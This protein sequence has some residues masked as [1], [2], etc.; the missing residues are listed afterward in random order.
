[1]T[2]KNRIYVLLSLPFF[3]FLHLGNYLNIIFMKKMKHLLI[4]L[5]TLIA[6]S[7]TA[8]MSYPVPMDEAV[9]TGK[10]DNGL[11]YYVRHNGY[12]EHRVNFYIAQRVGSIQENDDQRGLAHFLEHMAFNGSDHFRGNEL[13]EYCRSLG[14]EFGGDLNAYT[15]IDQTVYRICN[16]PSA[17]QTALDSCLLILRDWS[18]GL[19]LEADEIQ[20]ERGVIHEEWRLRTSPI[21]R[22]LE[23]NLEALYPGSKYGKRM[24][25]GLMEIID[26][27]EP[28]VLRDYYHKWYR[29]DNQAII[30]VGDVDVDHTVAK[31]RELFAPIPLAA[32]AAPVVKEPVPDTPQPIVVIDKD[33]EQRTNIVEVMFKHEAEPDSVKSDMMYLM[34]CYVKDMVTNMLNTRLQEVALE[35]DCPFVNASC[36]DGSY[37]LAHTV[38]CFSLSIMPKEGKTTEAV[39]AAYTEVERALQHGFTASEYSRA[40]AEYLS[41]LD[42]AYTNRNKTENSRFGDACRDH[43]LSN[44]PLTSIE[45]DKQV[46]D[47]M[48]PQ[49]PV[50]AA[51]EM[52]RDLVS[53]TD[54]NVVI[55]SFNNDKE[56]AT[57]PTA[58]VLYGAIK[59]VR[60]Q[61]L[62]AWVDNV[63]DEPLIANM[64]E[65]GRIVSEE[66][67]TT[68]GYKKWQLSNGAKVV[69]KKT[70]FKDDEIMM[71][72]YSK[73]GSSILGVED[74]VNASLMGA[75]VSSSKL[76]GFTSTELEKALAGKQASVSFVMADQHENFHG[77]TTP[78][79]LETLMQLLYLNFT[80]V[81]K[82]E[83]TYNTLVNMLETQLKNKS[84]SPEMA[85]SDSMSVTLYDHNPRKASLD[86]ERLKMLNHDRLLQIFHERTANAG[87]YTFIFVGNFDESQLRNLSEQYLASLPDNGVRDT[88]RPV[89]T[90][91]QGKA[92]NHFKR[93]METAKAN[94]IMYWYNNT[95]P[96]SLDNHIKADAAGQVLEMIYLKKIREEA[97]A[98]YSASAGGGASLSLDT[99]W[100]MMM[101]VC[102]MKPEQAD[103][104]LNIMRTEAH[105]LCKSVDADML[106][107]VKELMLKQADDKARR[108]NYWMGII[109]TFDEYGIDRHTNYKALV[110]ALTPQ[111]VSQF[112][113]D[114]IF[115]NANSVEVV[116]MPE[117]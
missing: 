43:F 32:N 27:F 17:R 58:D 82:D 8:Q 116:M 100:T 53:K 35:P 16:V 89:A 5:L 6:G 91:H 44:E 51:N 14:V 81:E 98:A 80:S 9:K 4:F 11:T 40:R 28:Q 41:L 77:R 10:L 75:V 78:K 59:N 97:S 110:G 90:Y 114:V 67:N 49:L 23:R 109:R 1:M 25:I 76:G 112:V 93:K 103:E 7:A 113:N 62:T 96:F 88:P 30:V 52:L 94:S 56:G 61:K 38:D 73:G 2:W 55:L 108:N 3:V 111:N 99:P 36:E 72:A 66:E 79:D 87:D 42:K 33:K 68:L 117:N 13:I 47:M 65:K 45:F 104:A 48:A 115:T 34:A 86:I 50:D 101:G 20:K 85:F 31:I 71:Q 26:N 64:P 21:M 24:P 29:P 15:G 46:M 102:P 83:K 74:V 69:L 39:Q 19:L 107:K 84:L 106:G 105:A 57:Y 54:S 70:D 95:V 22:M 37:I 92:V 63:K 12:P 60:A 18:C